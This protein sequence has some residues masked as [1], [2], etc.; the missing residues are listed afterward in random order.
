MKLAGETQRIE[1]IPDSYA[2]L[3]AAVTSRPVQANVGLDVWVDAV[4]TAWHAKTTASLVHVEI[5]LD[6]LSTSRLDGPPATRRLLSRAGFTALSCGHQNLQQEEPR[7][8]QA[9]Q[10]RS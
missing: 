7:V 9:P 10:S 1:L 8:K 4:V 3:T 6:R 2:A 5:S